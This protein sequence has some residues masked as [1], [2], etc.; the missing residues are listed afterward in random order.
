MNPLEAASPARLSSRTRA[1]A[2]VRVLV[3]AALAFLG[4]VL[5]AVGAIALAVRLVPFDPASLESP[6]R[7]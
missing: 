1:R 7:D 5:L 2:L 3:A 4:L 6:E